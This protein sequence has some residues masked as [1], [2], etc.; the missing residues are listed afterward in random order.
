MG[1]RAWA[2]AACTAWAHLRLAA[3]ALD[4]EARTT[5]AHWRLAART[6][7][8]EAL[9]ALEAGPRAAERT[10]LAVCAWANAAA[11]AAGVV[12]FSLVA[13]GDLVVHNV[14][15]RRTVPPHAAAARAEVDDGAKSWVVRS[16]RSQRRELFRETINGAVT[17][18][19][20]LVEAA[21]CFT[22]L[23]TTP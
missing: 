13:H 1:H 2:A 8:G 6:L 4:M 12:L 23:C 11:T 5:Q 18:V 21:Q 17:R 16:P 20:T 14:W 15:C 9:D 22:K 10:G 19:V 7:C 3:R